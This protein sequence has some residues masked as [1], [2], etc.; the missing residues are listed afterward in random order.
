MKKV[1]SFLI[2]LL[3]PA[4]FALAQYDLGDAELNESIN[5]ITSKAKTQFSE[6]KTFITQNYGVGRDKYDMWQNSI[7]MNLGDIYLAVEIAK[8]SRRSQDD[9]I[10]SYKKNKAQG[11][12]VIAKEFGVKPGT[13]A[14]EVL[15]GHAYQKANGKPRPVVA[16]SKPKSKTPAKKATPAKK[17]KPKETVKPK[18]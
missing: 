9:V 7:G 2:Y 6:F 11:W 4:S 14:F 8:V 12:G 5:T 18:T 1:A 17:T 13:D 16:K 10:A 15:K 3:V